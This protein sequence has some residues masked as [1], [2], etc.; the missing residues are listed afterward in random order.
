MVESLESFTFEEISECRKHCP[1]VDRYFQVV[2]ATPQDELDQLRFERNVHWLRAALATYWK[3]TTTEEV[4]RFWSQTTDEIVQKAWLMSFGADF[5][6]IL[7]AL[8][9]W[10]SK[11]LNLSSDIDFLIVSEDRVVVPEEKLRRFQ[12]L[13]SEKTSF[14][15]C[16]RLDWDL[17]P[18]GRLGPL[19]SSAGQ[20]EDYYGNYGQ[21]WERLVFV[22]LRPV[23]GSEHIHTRL[24]RFLERFTY[25]K[26][27]DFSVV[28]DLKEIR[29]QLHNKAPKDS[30]S[31]HLKLHKGGIR[32]IELYTH[33]LQIIHGGRE[34]RVRGV[35]TTQAL[36]ALV[37]FGFL[38][39]KD[40]EFLEKTY[41]EFRHWENWIQIK[42][43]RQTHTLFLQEVSDSDV[44]ETL[45]NRALKVCEILVH[46]FGSLIETSHLPMSEEEQEAW[47]VKLGF[48]SE[49]VREVWP[50]LMAAESR[51]QR[52]THDERVR[53][54]FLYQ[55]VEELA[56]S[57]LDKNLGLSLLYEFVHAIR[58]KASFFT[59][60]LREPK[61][62]RDLAWFFSTSPYLGGL[63]ASRP[64]LLDH[65][66]LGVQEQPSTDMGQFL[67][68][69]V[70][71]R[72]GGELVISHHFLAQRD[73]GALT[74]ALSTMAD[75]ICQ[76]LL[77]RVRE[78]IDQNSHL[79]IVALGKW[80]G[81]ELGLHS[82][83]DFILVTSNPPQEKDHRIARRFVSRISE[84]HRGGK[85]YSIDMRLRPTG[86]A[87]PL[88]V[89]EQRWKQYIQQ[90]SEP[91]ERQAYLKSRPLNKLYWD[92]AHEVVQRGL[93]ETD[94][95]RLSEIRV[96]ILGEAKG[97]L[98]LKRVEG[99]ILDI[100]LSVQTALLL[101]RLLPKGPST[102]EMISTLE[103]ASSRWRQRGNELRR[104]YGEFRRWEQIHQ[105]TNLQSGASFMEG[106]S[107]FQRTA[108]L[109]G[110]SE[111]ELS[112][113]IHD[114]LEAVQTTLKDLDPRR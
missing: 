90:E 62:I 92:P 9:K 72:L 81:R 78:E 106:S 50:K 91:W 56:Q 96:K 71:R 5:P 99:G 20:V 29:S 70:D 101:H 75:D 42:E 33:S 93:S 34:P 74:E 107:G 102:L 1:A 86:K 2:S 89:E 98:D 17:R 103:E 10:G 30:E 35:S 82:D 11:E 64:E 76:L 27:L 104:F 95:K 21:T 109:F 54:E 22:R 108:H 73:V 55:F 110:K 46:L 77:D 79:N 19:I 44:L 3:K 114:A 25:R 61:L 67:E 66:M 40:G 94:L 26:H 14:G 113:S 83:I 4:C 47:L 8:G 87:G 49:L 85:I 36:R 24:K 51:S 80:G 31:L 38:D 69:M 57:P 59:L 12:R 43:D 52:Q 84:P 63:L 37:Q 15:F 97:P 105:L 112:A 23:I 100:E 111:A 65:F 39:P 48:S 6:A 13:L 7:F 45:K 32:D 68:E 41:W 60:L 18:G 58:A 16:F 88:L 53:R 28:E